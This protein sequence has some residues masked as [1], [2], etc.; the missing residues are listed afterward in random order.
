MEHQTQ[1]PTRMLLLLKWNTSITLRNPF[2]YFNTHLA[3][4]SLDGEYL[5]LLVCVMSV[6]S[7]LD[8]ESVGLKAVD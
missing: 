5:Y 3:L 7:W 1:Y 8:D 6:C 4:N 2:H